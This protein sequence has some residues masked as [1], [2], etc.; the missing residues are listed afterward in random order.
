LVH[1]NRFGVADDVEDG[2]KLVIGELEAE[3]QGGGD[4]APGAFGREVRGS[5]E[6]GERGV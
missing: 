5:G 6:R 1:C 4:N 2:V 3:D